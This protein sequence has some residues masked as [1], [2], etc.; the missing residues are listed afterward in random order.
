MTKNPVLQQDKKLTITMRLEPGCLGPDG[1]E[2]IEGFCRVAQERLGGVDTAFV[3]WSFVP[4]HDK[5]LP[6]MQY[7]VAGKRLSKPMARR[8]LELFG[9][10]FDEFEAQLHDQIAGLIEQYLGR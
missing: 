2:H 8:Y 1:T 9:R 5:S 10:E 4:R 7:D 6:E 3:H